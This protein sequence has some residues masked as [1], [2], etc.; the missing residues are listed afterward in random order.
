M[1]LMWC[2]LCGKILRKLMAW[3][4]GKLPFIK[5]K[6]YVSRSVKFVY[7]NAV[8]ITAR[9][10]APRNYCALPNLCSCKPRYSHNPVRML[11]VLPPLF[12]SLIFVNTSF[13]EIYEFGC[14]L[15]LFM[16]WYFLLLGTPTYMVS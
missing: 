13:I 12:G 9:S 15:F 7:I 6:R 11:K 10:H 14:Q 5:K 4:R 8:F 2:T 3:K 1:T 16:Y